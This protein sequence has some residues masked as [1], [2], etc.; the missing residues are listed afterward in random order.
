M[1]IM[2]KLNE[3]THKKIFN[4]RSELKETLPV[5]DTCT[6]LPLGKFIIDMVEVFG[7][8]I[9]EALDTIWSVAPL[10]RIHGLELVELIDNA[11]N[12]DTGNKP[13]TLML[14]SELP[15]G[16]WLSADKAIVI[17]HKKI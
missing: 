14:L 16:R 10:S 9:T 3:G 5:C 4:L 8:I 2:F 1:D 17:V 15:K 13:A 6:V 7:S 12:A 11:D